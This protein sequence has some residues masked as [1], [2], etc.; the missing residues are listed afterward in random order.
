MSQSTI[1][2]V[3]SGPMAIEYAKIFKSLGIELVVVGRGK[4]SAEKFTAETGLPVSLG[5]I[6]TWLTN[7]SNELPQRA[8]VAVGEKWIG[9]TAKSLIDRGV[10]L[11]GLAKALSANLMPSDTELPGLTC[12]RAS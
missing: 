7:R 12:L 11:L 8:I 5:G 10:R 2:L 6:D 3:G 9:A 4:S 1:L